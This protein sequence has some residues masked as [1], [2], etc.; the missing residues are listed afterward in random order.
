MD[1]AIDESAA[2]AALRRFQRAHQD[3]RSAEEARRTAKVER[4]SAIEDAKAAGLTLREIG[5]RVG[6]SHERIRQMA[7]P[8][9]QPNE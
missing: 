5:R 4:A 8:S 2:E 1:R 3:M 7:E 9:A 6:L